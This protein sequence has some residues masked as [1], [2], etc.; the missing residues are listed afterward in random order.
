MI[1]AICTVKAEA[2]T[3]V[4]NK[5][6]SAVYNLS[7]K[8]N[9]LTKGAQNDAGKCFGVL[10]DMMCKDESVKQRFELTLVDNTNCGHCEQGSSINTPSLY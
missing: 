1:K 2:N 10:L 5:H 6:L 7:M 9:V 8:S 3:R 4:Q